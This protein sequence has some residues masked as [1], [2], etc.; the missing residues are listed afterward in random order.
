ML[1][2]LAPQRTLFSDQKFQ[3]VVTDA[4]FQFV[5][6]FDADLF[7]KIH[8]FLWSIV[9]M[10]HKFMWMRHGWPSI[11]TCL[12][13]NKP[14]FSPTHS[15][16]NLKPVFCSTRPY[17]THSLPNSKFGS[18]PLTTFSTNCTHATPSKRTCVYTNS[19]VSPSSP[20]RLS[21]AAQRPDILHAATPITW[22]VARWRTFWLRWQ[23]PDRCSQTLSGQR[24]AG[25]VPPQPCN[26]GDQVCVQGSGAQRRKTDPGK[27]YPKLGI[28]KLE[29]TRYS[30][31]QRLESVIQTTA[32]RDSKD[33]KRVYWKE[34]W[35][36]YVRKGCWVGY[37]LRAV[38]I[39][40]NRAR[41]LKRNMVK[42]QKAYGICKYQ[43]RWS[44]IYNFPI[45]FNHGNIYET[46][47]IGSVVVIEYLLV[48]H[49][50]FCQYQINTTAPDRTCFRIELYRSA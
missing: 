5:A 32:L 7:W 12:Q 37:R 22:S 19:H 28:G 27:V 20:P 38:E 35:W 11:K 16:P 1:V 41:Y 14:G 31:A 42:L 15:L 33:L 18:L 25:S 45:N 49:N 24:H 43:H 17:L 2:Q 10:E 13:T 8:K 40:W 44:S 30:M 26:G 34:T 9:W 29:E 23:K 39:K 47:E 46:F 48:R 21:P 36:K 4:F 50:T 6:E 3:P